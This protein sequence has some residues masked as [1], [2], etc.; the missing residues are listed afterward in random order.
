MGDVPAN[1]GADYRKVMSRIKIRLYPNDIPII[2][3][4]LFINHWM[5]YVCMYVCMYMR[6]VLSDIAT[7]RQQENIINYIYIYVSHYI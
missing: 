1:H 7:F 3:Y 5:K 4:K 6:S 2:S